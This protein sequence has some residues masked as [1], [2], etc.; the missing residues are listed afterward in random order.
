MADIWEK[1]K[2]ERTSPSGDLFLCQVW[3]SCAFLSSS[4]LADKNCSEKEEE[5][6]DLTFREISDVTQEDFYKIRSEP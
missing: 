1:I 3:L 5:E 2:A 6:L 4:K